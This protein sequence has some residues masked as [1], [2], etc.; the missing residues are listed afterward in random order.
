MNNIKFTSLKITLL[1]KV[2]HHSLMLVR[3]PPF[4]IIQRIKQLQ[5]NYQVHLVY[6]HI[7]S[8]LEVLSL[9]L[10]C[11]FLSYIVRSFSL[12]LLWGMINTYQMIT[13]MPLFKVSMPANALYF[14]SILVNTAKLDFV[15][16]SYTLQVKDYI[17]VRSIIST[18]LEWCQPSV[19]GS[20]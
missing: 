13:H 14:F 1:K 10:F 8:F 9:T 18:I 5:I 3:L 11:K 6:P 12:S 2:S 4:K 17:L 15:P 7:L 20:N 16:A 19:L